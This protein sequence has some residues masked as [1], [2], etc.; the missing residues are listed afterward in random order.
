MILFIHRSNA[1]WSDTFHRLVCEWQFNADCSVSGR[2]R[3]GGVSQINLRPI[4]VIRCFCRKEE[5]LHAANSACVK[6][7]V[8]WIV[9]WSIPT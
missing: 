6:K 9:Q 7:I 3:V 2:G 4:Y 8:E 1:D 5:M